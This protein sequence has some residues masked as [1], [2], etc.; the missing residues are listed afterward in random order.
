MTQLVIIVTMPQDA[1]KVAALLRT[2]GEVWPDANVTT[3]PRASTPERQVTCE[4][5]GA[6]MVWIDAQ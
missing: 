2:V 6:G 5:P 3:E 1:R 4:F